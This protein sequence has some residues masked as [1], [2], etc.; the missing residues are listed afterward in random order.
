MIYRMIYRSSG[1]SLVLLAMVATPHLANAAPPAGADIEVWVRGQATPDNGAPQRLRSR[2]FRLD[3]LP[4]V[5]GER[6]DVQYGDSRRYRGVAVRDILARY[7]P[8]RAL[9]LAILHFTNGMAV[10]IPFRDD[11][12][13][14]RLDPFVARAWQ[15]RRGGRFQ[16]G[17]LPSVSNQDAAGVRRPIEFSGNKLVVAQRWHPEVPPGGQPEFSP[18][19]HTDTLA[20]I[21]LVSAKPYYAQFDGGGDALAQRGLALFRQ[22]C[23]FCHG[24]RQV[25]AR[26]GWDF[27]DA[28]AIH[29]YKESA[30]HLYHNVAHKPRNAGALGLMMPALGFVSEADAAALRAWMMALSRS[31][32]PR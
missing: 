27:V 14:R 4:V 16:V 20:G 7:A 22:Q 23:Q 6:H 5:E 26:F 30:A 31:P 15:A 8:D 17:G 10:P 2:R 13:M 19:A 28:P 24:A 21:E 29:A 32:M 25:G 12:A 9:D 18:W 1:T 3:R 11:D